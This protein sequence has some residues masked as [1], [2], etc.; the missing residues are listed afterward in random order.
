VARVTPRNA[1]SRISYGFCRSV[2]AELIGLLPSTSRDAGLIRALKPSYQN[3]TLFMP[4]TALLEP[5][6]SIQIAN[7]WSEVDSSGSLLPRNGH[8]TLLLSSQQCYAGPPLVL[9]LSHVD[10]S[11]SVGVSWPSTLRVKGTVTASLLRNGQY[12]QQWTAEVTSDGSFAFS[13]T[14]PFGDYR[15]DVHIGAWHTSAEWKASASLWN[16]STDTVGTDLTALLSNHVPHTLLPPSRQLATAFIHC[17]SSCDWPQMDVHVTWEGVH[18]Q[19][20]AIVTDGDAGVLLGALGCGI[21]RIGVSG[22]DRVSSAPLMFEPSIR[23]IDF[24][25]PSAPLSAHFAV[26]GMVVVGRVATVAFEAAGNS[27]LSDTRLGGI[28]VSLKD[29]QEAVTQDDGGFTFTLAWNPEQKAGISVSGSMSASHVGAQDVNAV[30]S[31]GRQVLPT[32][33]IVSYAACGK[34]ALGEKLVGVLPLAWRMM[35]VFRR[36]S[37]ALQVS[38]SLPFPL[39]AHYPASSTPYVHAFYSTPS[40]LAAHAVQPEYPATVANQGGNM[41]P[42]QPQ[43][44]MFTNI[45]N[46]L[47][48][49][50]GWYTWIARLFVGIGEFLSAIVPCSCTESAFAFIHAMLRHLPSALLTLSKAEGRGVEASWLT[51]N[52]SQEPHKFYTSIFGSDD[53]EAIGT[54]VGYVHTDTDGSFCFPS[55]GPGHYILLPGMALA[56]IER[57]GVLVYPL[58][59]SFSVGLE[60]S[61]PTVMRDLHFTVDWPTVAGSLN[62]IGAQPD[63]MTLQLVPHADEEYAAHVSS[64]PFLIP[65]RRPIHIALSQEGSGSN[66]ATTHECQFDQ[67]YERLLQGGRG[68]S[69][70]RPLYP[71]FVS[72]DGRTDQD[73]LINATACSSNRTSLFGPL[74]YTSVVGGRSTN[75]FAFFGVW[76]GRYDLQVLSHDAGSPRCWNVAHT[77]HAAGSLV[78]PV[79]SYLLDVNVIE[80]GRKIALLS[81]SPGHSFPARIAS[82]DGSVHVRVGSDIPCVRGDNAEIHFPSCAVISM[83]SVASRDVDRFPPHASNASY[84]Y[85]A[86]RDVIHHGGEVVS[87]PAVA[88]VT[89]VMYS[90]AIYVTSWE[91]ACEELLKLT[92]N[93]QAAALPLT[94]EYRGYQSILSAQYVVSVPMTSG[95]SVVAQLEGSQDVLKTFES[96]RLEFDLQSQVDFGSSFQ[97][98]CDAGMRSLLIMS[99][100]STPHVGTV[101]PPLVFPSS[102]PFLYTIQGAAQGV[103]VH[104]HFIG[105]ALLVDQH[106]LRPV[107]TSPDDNGSYHVELPALPVVSRPPA[108]SPASLYVGAWSLSTPGYNLCPHMD[109]GSRLIAF[110]ECRLPSLTF[111][112]HP[113]LPDVE[114]TINISA[115]GPYEQQ[116]SFRVS[117]DIATSQ[118]GC[119]VQFPHALPEGVFVAHLEGEA[120]DFFSAD[121]IKDFI[122]FSVTHNSENTLVDVHTKLRE[123]VVQGTAGGS[124]SVVAGQ[125]GHAVAHA[126]TRPD[127]TFALHI[128]YARLGA[129]DGIWQDSVI[130][131][132]EPLY[133]VKRE[134]GNG[135]QGLTLVRTLPDA[136]LFDAPAVPASTISQAFTLLVLIASAGYY[137]TSFFSVREESK[138]KVRT[139]TA[140]SL[141]IT[142]VIQLEPTLSELASPSRHR[143]RAKS[144][145][146]KEA[147]SAVVR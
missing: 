68:P 102:S 25:A 70:V 137:A 126:H 127:G 24:C 125:H 128:P 147:P 130:P 54:L 15:V 113:C 122:E 73:L 9:S 48:S 135:C 132:G 63:S 36:Q 40:Q 118:G 109:S 67:M 112:L 29:G 23:S 41:H 115:V 69:S 85:D 58:G 108:H 19:Q 120:H 129:I 14:L 123:C 145:S 78:V 33:L 101:L 62:F 134:T 22:K 104:A 59:Y 34:V 77:T 37:P 88:T 75:S 42:T 39:A 72:P 138:G 10:V 38:D 91:I 146:K 64:L 52:S 100:V 12:E 21:T 144:L 61:Q 11:G 103:K 140:S 97:A 99:G 43:V 46:S 95:L 89:R 142:R 6:A 1:R 7:I 28:V 110:S 66:G 47:N 116:G 49:V 96:T 90:G 8:S 17:G 51:F 27:N 117:A 79:A 143:N 111:Q 45:R 94:C 16:N 133:R 93:L 5:S 55:L 121:G 60:P 53:S 131:L 13:S 76:P 83:R 35:R 65:E 107:Q 136:P 87:L 56:E 26:T 18:G 44:P 106:L 119:T 82:V 114:M 86:A 105:G 92:V 124:S 50:A 32:S 84:T 4:F 139:P 31:P 3:D 98:F 141:H 80:A 71:D 30:V 20:A 2:A 57:V 81:D 74:P